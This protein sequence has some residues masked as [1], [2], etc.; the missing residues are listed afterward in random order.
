MIGLILAA[1]A[2]NYFYPQIKSPSANWAVFLDTNQAVNFMNLSSWAVAA[3][4]GSLIGATQS[5]PEV[6]TTAADAAGIGDNLITINTSALTANFARIIFQWEQR[7]PVLKN[8]K[9]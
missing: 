6:P 3:F 9:S 1:S 2:L 5:T 7:P 4:V 8:C